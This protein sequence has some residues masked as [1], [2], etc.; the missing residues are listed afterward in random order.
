MPN[1]SAPA[2]PRL[3]PPVA[4]E[5]VQVEHEHPHQAI[6]DTAGSQG[7]DLIVVASHG[8]QGISAIALGG[9]T[10]EGHKPLPPIDIA[11]A[12]RMNSIVVRPHSCIGLARAEGSH[13]LPYWASSEMSLFV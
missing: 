9:E 12:V 13:T 3:K 4:C 5:T 7:C 11:N 10:V 2:P 8:R 6:I 1:G